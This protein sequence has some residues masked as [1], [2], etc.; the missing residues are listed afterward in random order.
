MKKAY[1]YYFYNIV[2]FINFFF[3]KSLTSC[4]NRYYHSFKTAII[5]L[6]SLEKRHILDNL[7]GLSEQIDTQEKLLRFFESVRDHTNLK[8]IQEQHTKKG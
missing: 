7:K 3:E 5:N 6:G 2:T 4:F 1:I 8:N